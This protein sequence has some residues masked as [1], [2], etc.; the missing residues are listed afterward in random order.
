M[1]D[2]QIEFWAE[3]FHRLEAI[4][5]VRSAHHLTFGQFMSGDPSEH[6]R[7]IHIYFANPALLSDRRQGGNV[8]LVT[9]LENGAALVLCGAMEMD[10]QQ[11]TALG[12]AAEQLLRKQQIAANVFDAMNVHAMQEAEDLR[13]ERKHT[14]EMRGGRY[15]EA[16]HDRYPPCKWKT[17]GR[18]HV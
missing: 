8:T 6:E 5:K 17:R 11:R 4:Y 18:L 1:S 14:Q 15:I 2:E 13:F 9:F 12:E 16:I 3:I 7:W 10:A